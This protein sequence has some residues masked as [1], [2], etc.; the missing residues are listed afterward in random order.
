[1]SGCPGYYFGRWQQQLCSGGVEAASSGR[2]CGCWGLAIDQIPA[3]RG[4]AGPQGGRA[5][6]PSPPSSSLLVSPPGLAPL[7]L[8]LG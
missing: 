4:E 5:Y 2:R 6:Y 3:G 7:A 8:L 1:M